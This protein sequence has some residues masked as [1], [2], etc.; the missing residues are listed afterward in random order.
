MQII[1]SRKSL[2]A[3]FATLIPASLVRGV[4]KTPLAPAT[5]RRD[6]EAFDA[7][8]REHGD[9]FRRF[10]TRKVRE[11]DRDDVLQETWMRA[12]QAFPNF[13]GRSSVRTWLYSVCYHTVQDY[14][15]R[16]RIRPIA[17][18]LFQNEEGSA[19]FPSEFSGV[20]LR[21]SMREFWE[22]CSPGERELLSMYYSD[23]LALPEISRILNR[24][25]N[26]V[27]YQFYRAHEGVREKLLGAAPEEFWA[28]RA[29]GGR[30]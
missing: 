7:V 26:T 2:V 5:D 22:S 16:E 21:E 9:F 13:D 6:R 17:E 25:L 19:Y 1:F 23:G 4:R 12:W 29:S 3:F 24:N 11:S 27:K 18:D 28:G 30:R 14:W 15:R 8:V 20:D 10:V